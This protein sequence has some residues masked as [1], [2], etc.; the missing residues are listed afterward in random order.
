[1]PSFGNLGRNGAAFWVGAGN[2]DI[3]IISGTRA[4]GEMGVIDGFWGS[5]N[6]GGVVHFES[7]VHTALWVNMVVSNNGVISTNA[8]AGNG[9][10]IFVNSGRLGMELKNVILYNNQA[11]SKFSGANATAHGG[12]IFFNGTGTLTMSDVRFINNSGSAWGSAATPV[13][14][15]G[16]L[17]AIGGA[18]I[19]M[20]G[21]TFSG[22]TVKATVGTSNATAHGGAIYQTGAATKSFFTNVVFVS[23]TSQNQGGAIFMP[24]ASG[25]IEF[26]NVLFKNNTAGGVGGAISMNGANAAKAT[27]NNVTFEQNS[28]NLNG[29]AVA[30]AQ[31]GV[32]A[33]FNNVVFASNTS[34][35]DSGAL[36]L[37]TGAN[38]KI[39]GALF[40]NNI[41]K[42]GGAAGGAIY[43][44]DSNT[45]L[46]VTSAT[47]RGNSVTGVNASSQNARGGAVYQYWAT[48]NYTNVLFDQNNADADG[49]AMYVTI[50][51]NGTAMAALGNATFTGNRAGR[52]G[53]L[54]VRLASSNT[55]I[56]GV[57]FSM[58]G[59]T[60]S[61]NRALSINGAAAEGLGGAVYMDN[62]GPTEE[63]GSVTFNDVSFVNNTAKGSI[64]AGGAIAMTGVGPSLE[65]NIGISS[66]GQNLI[67]LGNIAYG[68]GASAM[69]ELGGFLYSS[70]S[71]TVNFNVAA[72][73]TL[74]IGGTANVR[75]DSIVGGTDTRININAAD[76]ANTGSLILHADNSANRAPIMISS[77]AVLLGNRNARLGGNITVNPGATF[78]G[79]GTVSDAA[80]MVTIDSGYLTI[81]ASHLDA[82]V[83]AP[84]QLTIAGGLTLINSTINYDIYS[85][86]Q[87]DLLI[88]DGTLSLTGTTNIDVNMFRSGTYKL[89]ENITT[90]FG[91]DF[92]PDDWFA[93]ATFAGSALGGDSAERYRIIDNDLYLILSAANHIL[94]WTG[95]TNNLW[96]SVVNNWSGTNTTQ[97]TNGDIVIFDDTV[98]T[99][100]A[101]IVTVSN[102]GVEAAEMLV[103]GTGDYA[104]N[105]SGAIVTSLENTSLTD[106]ATGK[107]IKDGSGTLDF[108]ALTGTNQF[109]NGVD[110]KA[111]K[112]LVSSAAQLGAALSQ[113][114][115]LG[116]TASSGTLAIA[117]GNALDIDGAVAAPGA[118]RITIASGNAGGIDLAANSSLTLRNS[119]VASSDGGAISIAAGG[120]FNL[121]AGA[122]A[123]YTF[124][125]NTAA[126]SQNGGAIFNAGL[127]TLANATF[128]DNTAG[129]QGGAIYNTGALALNVTAAGDTATF[130]GNTAGSGATAAANSI[131]TDATANNAAVTLNIASGGIFDMRDPMSGSAANGNAITITSTGSGLWKLSGTSAFAADATASSRT[132]LSVSSGTL[133][134]E[135]NAA[136]SLAGASS[137]I[138]LGGAAGP[139][140]LDIA[141]GNT[142]AAPAITFAGNSRL[143]FTNPSI[144][145]TLRLVGSATFNSTVWD[146]RTTLGNTADNIAVT[147]PA[148][149]LGANTLNITRWNSGTY[150]LLA[151]DSALA[152]GAPATF[153]PV[154]Y[155]GSALIARQSAALGFDATGKNL[156]LKLIS[157]NTTLA[158][159]GSV[160]NTWSNADANWTDGDTRF[161]AHDTVTF[162]DNAPATARTITIATEGVQVADMI[163]DT[164]GTYRF[165]GNGAIES[166]AA[167]TTLASATGA[168][169]KLGAGSLILENTAANNFAG[170]INIA[171][172][173]VTGNV[174]T[175]G[176]GAPGITLSNDSA[177]IF[178]QAIDA[179]YTRNIT[180]NGSLTKTNTGNLTLSGT[181]TYTGVTKLDA[182]ALTLANVNQ[183]AASA[184]I[185]LAASTTLSTGA[186]AQQLNHL[187]GAGNIATGA[188]ALTFANTAAD[189]L[190]TGTISGPAALTKTGANTLTLA[191]DNTATG[192]TTITGGT[193]RLG[194]GGAAGS[195]AGAIVNNAALTL[196]HGAN[197]TTLTNDIT[198]T[199]LINKLVADTGA[200]ALTGNSASFSGTTNIYA[201]SLILSGTN[202]KLGGLVTLAAGAGFGGNGTAT[203][204]VVTLGGNTITAGLTHNDGSTTA[205]QTLSIG[206]TLS[207]AAATKLR[208]DLYAGDASDLITAGALARTGTSTVDVN[209]ASSGTYKLIATTAA[210]AAAYAG[211][212]VTT[213]NGSTISARVSGSYTADANNLYLVLSTTNVAA[214]KWSGTNTNQWVENLNNWQSAD[215]KFFAGDSVIFDDTAAGTHEVVVNAGGVRASDMLVSTADTYTFTGGAIITSTDNSTIGA[216]TAGKL[217]KDGAGALILNNGANNFT[218][219][220]EIT[221]GILQGNALTLAAGPAGITNN[222]TLIFDQVVTGTYSNAVVGSGSLVK[223][224]AG[225]LT[226]TNNT[227]TYTGGITVTAGTLELQ[228]SGTKTQGTIDIV[229]DAALHIS[230]GAAYTIENELT[231]AGTLH[232]SL[233]APASAVTFTTASGTFFNG[234]VR[235]GRSALA[236]DNTTDTAL[237]KASLDLGSGNTT[238]VAPVTQHIANLALNGATLIFTTTTP[239][240]PAAAGVIQTGNLALNSGTVRV[241]LPAGGFPNPPVAGSTNIFSQDDGP[242]ITRLITATGDIA[243]NVTNLTLVNASGSAATTQTAAITESGVT[244]ANANYD[245][246]LDETGGLA[247][248]Y[249]LTSID[250]VDGQTL[251]LAPDS[252]AEGTDTELRAAITGTGNLSIAAA[253]AADATVALG[254][255][256]NTF[257]GTT[258]ITSG[259]LRLDAINALGTGGANG[260][261]VAENA[262]VNLN[263]N[264][265]TIATL[266]SGTGALI[267]L[268]GATLTVT[269]GGIN[270]GALTGSGSLAIAG[271]NL[272]LNAAAPDLVAR[273]GIATSAT[274]TLGNAEALGRDRIGLE[275]PGSELVFSV[276]TSGTFANSISGTG[277]IVM[278]GTGTVAMS[279]ANTGFSGSATVNSGHLVMANVNA[280]GASTPFTVNNGGN[281]DYAANGTVPNRIGGS[282]TLNFIAGSQVI[283][284]SNSIANINV[285]NG[286]TITGSNVAAFGT[287]S[288]HLN[289]DN[290]T[291]TIGLN[292]M[293]IGRVALS[294]TGRLGFNV[295]GTT[296]KHA[297]LTSLSSTGTEARLVFNTNIGNQTNDKLT[298]L[299]PVAGTYNIALSNTG[300]APIPYDVTIDL[301]SNAGGAANYLM[302]SDTISISVFKY[303]ITT[304]TA[305]GLKLHIHNTGDLSEVGSYIVNTVGAIPL[306]WFSEL[307]NI[308]KRMGDIRLGSRAKRGVDTW[309]RSYAQRIEVN[310]NVTGVPFNEEQYSV[311]GGIDYGGKLR[312]G[313]SVYIGGFYGYGATSRNVENAIGTGNTE[314][315]F[316]GLYLTTLAPHGWYL[317]LV[318]KYNYFKNNYHTYAGGSESIDAEYSSEAW[319]GSVELGNVI[320]FKDSKWYIQPQLQWAI[321]TFTN[322]QYTTSNDITVRF[323]SGNVTQLRAGV[324][325]GYKYVSK[326]G[327]IFQPYAKIDA[328]R[329]WGSDCLVYVG[330]QSWDT[331]IDGDRV[332]GGIGFNWVPL[333][334]F[335]VYLDYGYSKAKDYTK[336]YEFTV[337]IHREW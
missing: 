23:N 233:D 78:G 126:A 227:N 206:G 122:G 26:N 193:L 46:V 55:L 255:A 124:A 194:N 62:A 330:L 244:V 76:P 238:T 96:A 150:T 192:I 212:L 141:G 264:A 8:A 246:T 48:G 303:S 128:T 268:G 92:N 259:M 222:A 129:G 104:F 172:G 315:M 270:D 288:T 97:F 196:N 231:G 113:I 34:A 267:D 56:G 290:A 213:I 120:I 11:I 103:T 157:S 100:T 86:S 134:L 195:V 25:T 323:T 190:Y 282:G 180:G 1:M 260:L 296:F 254:N 71:N 207:L 278:A 147:G 173:S 223:Q 15:G 57:N 284:G 101:R 99:D 140:H 241:D 111:G 166:G 165:T 13:S 175:L 32:V 265:Q 6:G 89:V 285:L 294:G 52:G 176:A 300:A 106:I 105:G 209:T 36:W 138:T 245:Y 35:A 95:S 279:V 184:T 12:A 7:G 217:T 179:D 110:L 24:G 230:N 234:T 177:I 242:I 266:G 191:G 239:G 311:D 159:R 117:S 153:A 77:G 164:T 329:Q 202:A 273:T 90:A 299:N 221:G 256:A 308:T 321:S 137:S 43:A 295:T 169:T 305:D 115:F 59:G 112:W 151:S 307:D 136:I 247:V 163:V 83:T 216:A 64:G 178:D 229:E 60:F 220:I 73:K 70:G 74:T 5:G 203:G 51:Q 167:G 20:D 291:A 79:Y 283:T 324:M 81:G 40:S 328:A 67:Y 66:T 42:A 69:A 58:S 219:G 183:I 275:G 204:N 114:N 319:G 274:V 31:A 127:L 250:L 44:R 121:T 208:Y 4:N 14:Y 2:G 109:Q 156:V 188:G 185:A 211:D 280:L 333:K 45:E 225:T 144:G 108:T 54:A 63:P 18:T 87:S 41:V 135:Q 252:G 174:S 10:A 161:I 235:L 258:T 262:A 314:S 182:G 168:L 61:T 281:L 28:A 160:N 37:R 158:W 145:D 91:G 210:F 152:V 3:T 72:G 170:G 29:G 85:A 132:N 310:D 240:D 298:I 27:F 226:L 19:I 155:N 199:G 30:M 75:A 94:T 237:G 107:L 181:T 287:P 248:T 131:H 47:F 93:A 17:Y 133:R 125:N 309:V 218:G 332:G 251:H 271:G 171:A 326:T 146:I 289:I 154:T 38:A 304:D 118:Q 228:N 243:G 16:A 53:A 320:Q 84:Q 148:A 130:S 123:T 272:I 197:N 263:E 297:T 205:P 331:A 253:T 261:V 98:S 189:T 302:V 142:I 33:T 187:T 313:F 335:R 334:G 316:G 232:I 139:A 292:E 236:L 215:Q 200:L 318:A 276:A 337:G 149:F 312:N 269:N 21:G 257:T 9:G 88:L 39:D 50:E 68:S 306:T 301:I 201:G 322:G 198:G 49:G 82:S 214:S 224:N 102:Y 22:N 249:A 286:A 293:V 116:T 317:D 119:L 80:G 65:L 143:T 277:S 325:A 186:N 336:P 162:D 327:K